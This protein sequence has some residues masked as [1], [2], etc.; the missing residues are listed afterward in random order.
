MLIKGIFSLNLELKRGINIITGKNAS[1]KTTLFNIIKWTL[2]DSK[3]D[4]WFFKNQFSSQCFFDREF[5]IKRDTS[6]IEIYSLDG[7]ILVSG[8]VLVRKKLMSYF[9]RT[10]TEKLEYSQFIDFYFVS[11]NPKG[12]RYLLKHSITEFFFLNELWTDIKEKKLLESKKIKKKIYPTS[13]DELYSLSINQVNKG[14]TES[15][16]KTLIYDLIGGKTSLKMQTK[17]YNSEILKWKDKNKIRK[18]KLDDEWY[19]DYNFTEFNVQFCKF[20]EECSFESTFISETIN[21]IFT[22]SGFRKIGFLSSSE[23]SFVYYAVMSFIIKHLPVKMPF[24]IDEPL[25]LLLDRKHVKD[26][27]SLFSFLPQVIFFSP[28]VDIEIPDELDHY[29]IMNFN[30]KDSIFYEAEYRILEKINEIAIEKKWVLDDEHFQTSLHIYQPDYVITI[31]DKKFGIALKL[32]SNPGTILQIREII[33]KNRSLYGF[34]LISGDK[35]SWIT[36]DETITEKISSEDNMKKIIIEK[37][38]GVI[39]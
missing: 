1:G 36:T 13:L 26:F 8:E 22:E 35:I 37:I 34:F 38:E 5:S 29:L 30:A 10:R 39:G 24:V 25:P 20:L 11:Q 12:L 15:V 7:D 3:K 19:S 14:E 18:E 23:N 27:L 31:E 2:G 21:Q 33:E 16:L 6:N 9:I 17:N 4:M 32:E 28:A